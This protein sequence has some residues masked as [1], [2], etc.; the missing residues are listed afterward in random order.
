MLRAY[1]FE[2]YLEG[3][4]PPALFVLEALAN[5]DYPAIRIK[6]PHSA[7]SRYIAIKI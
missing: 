4:A 1:L 5:F 6:D 3:A 7:P 2:S